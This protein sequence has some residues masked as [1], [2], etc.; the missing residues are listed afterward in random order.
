MDKQQPRQLR[1]FICSFPDCQAIYNKQWKLEAHMCKHTGVKPFVCDREGCGRSFCTKYHLARHELT[2]SG[3]RPFRC[4]LDG[5]TNGFTTNANLQKHISRIH[6]QEQKQYVCVFEGCGKIFK[7]NKQLKSHQCEEHTLLPLYQC[8]FEGCLK[9]FSFPNKLKRHEKVHRGN[10]CVE[11]ECSFIGR[12]WTEY[13]KHRRESHRVLLPC[14]KC[15]KVFRD[16]WFL[17]QHQQVHSEVRQVLKCPRE[18]CERSF[19]TTFNLQNHIGSFH[20]ELR[21]FTCPHAGCGKT[22]AMK[23]SLH[24]HG[25]VHNPELKKQRKHRPKRSLVSRLSGYKPGK[26]DFFPQ[27]QATQSIGSRQP[28]QISTGGSEPTDLSSLL[29]DT[30]LCNP[31]LTV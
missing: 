14:N 6:N 1:S 16:T 20:E 3:E 18:G 9:R 2:H 24:R 29:K 22:F 31:V 30:N 4:T 5:C 12:T 13:T 25:V 28:E 11:Q 21:P 7:K 10:P 27:Q 23:Q 26:R 8:S 17:E 19:T 15:N